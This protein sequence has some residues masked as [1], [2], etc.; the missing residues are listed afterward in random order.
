MAKRMTHLHAER[1]HLAIN[2]CGRVK[3]W[4]G[5]ATK[6]QAAL[7]LRAALACFLQL[8]KQGLPH[9]L[10]ETCCGSLTRG[11]HC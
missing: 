3:H 7:Q 5:R 1:S 9:R 4:L 11:A 10:H 2:M 6:A 8:R